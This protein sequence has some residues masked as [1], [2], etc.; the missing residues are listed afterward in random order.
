MDG[1]SYSLL[2]YL[3]VIIDKLRVILFYVMH[4]QPTVSFQV[5][6]QLIQVLKALP[7][8]RGIVQAGTMVAREKVLRAP[9][10]PP[11]P[12]S[13]DHLLY[14]QS[15]TF[16]AKTSPKKICHPSFSRVWEKV[17]MCCSRG[18]FVILYKSS[19]TN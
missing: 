2:V 3:L 17:S 11:L 10:L 18:Q 6:N 9:L 13:I 12:I 15:T 7:D 5:W 14:P 8:T 19:C 4:I 1:G 16:S